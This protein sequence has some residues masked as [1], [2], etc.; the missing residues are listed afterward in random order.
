LLAFAGIGRPQK[1]FDTLSRLGATLADGVS[2]PDHHLFEMRD[3]EALKAQADAIG[4]QLI[5]TEKDYVRLPPAWRDS[6][7]VLPVTA[8]FSDEAAID[9][10]LDHALAAFAEA[11]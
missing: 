8:Q 5:T 4:A 7:A 10:L 1:F 3:I 6:I 11:R 2:F 9:G